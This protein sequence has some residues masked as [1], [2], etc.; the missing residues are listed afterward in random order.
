M[1]ESPTRVLFIGVGN[2]YRGDDGAGIAV[3]RQLAR[4]VPPDIEVLEESGEGTA[5]VEAW[6]GATFV[7]VVDAIQSGAAP[8]TIYRFDACREH[9]AGGLHRSTHAFGVSGAIELARALNELPA[10]LVV[11]GI[12]GQDFTPGEGLSPAVQGAVECTAERILSEA[13][14]GRMPETEAAELG[15][16][17]DAVH[18]LA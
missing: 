17:D 15:V 14:C 1:N 5:L 2:P 4:R 10:H 13:M 16:S 6:Q 9:L 11:Y 18:V 7:I 3:A 8:G 12:E